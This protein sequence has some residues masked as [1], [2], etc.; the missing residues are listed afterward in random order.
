MSCSVQGNPQKDLA[1]SNLAAK[2]IVADTLSVCTRINAGSIVVSTDVPGT[3]V[4]IDAGG[5]S[6]VGPAGVVGAIGPQ[7]IQGVIGPGGLVGP[8]GPIGTVGIA[9]FIRI[10][11]APNDSVPP[12]QAFTIDTEVINT[13]PTSVIASAGAGGTVYTLAPG[14][15]VLDYEMSLGS[16]GSVAIYRG[17]TAGTLA[18][19]TNTIAGSSTATTWIHGRAVVD[20]RAGAQVVAISSVVGTAAVVTAGN[21]AGFF[22]IR[23]TIEKVG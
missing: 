9:E 1:V 20:T 6:V 17:A 23:L 15:Y 5:V 13:M 7:G 11:Q 2:N 19:D 21:A 16:A 12:G 4:I 10:I 8:A 18:V 3:N 14:I 22:M